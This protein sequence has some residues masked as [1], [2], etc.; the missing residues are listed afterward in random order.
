MTSSRPL[1]WRPMRTAP[2]DGTYIQI[3]YESF[4]DNGET[5]VGHG[6]WVECLHWNEV[7]QHIIDRRT[8]INCSP[9]KAAIPHWE[10][11]YVAVL[12]CGGRWTGQSYEP[13]SMCI[14]NP[15]GWLHLPEPPRTKRK[16]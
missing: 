12:D 1:R 13:R 9:I 6:R 11:A 15:L 7:Q 16:T 5:Y 4:S 8:L 10:V 3:A 2:K 14:H